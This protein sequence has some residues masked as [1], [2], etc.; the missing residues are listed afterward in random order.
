MAEEPIGPTLEQ[1]GR[2]P[3]GRR[4][5]GTGRTPTEEPTGAG[6]AGAEK[7]G[8]PT[9]EELLGLEGAGAQRMGLKEQQRGAPVQI[10]VTNNN[11]NIDAPFTFEGVGQETAEDLNSKIE[12]HLQG[13]FNEA[14]QNLS[15]AVVR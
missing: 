5:A 12:E 3:G 4:F 15:P 13:I 9:L 11:F 10:A 7:P 6:G 8:I 14:A 1:A 2:G